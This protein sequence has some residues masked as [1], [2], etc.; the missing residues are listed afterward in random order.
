MKALS[1]KEKIAAKKIQDLTD[2]INYFDNIYYNQDDQKINDFQYDLLRKELDSLEKEYPNLVSKNSPSF[3][4]GSKPTNEFNKIKHKQLMLS[5]NNAYSE[6]EVK[7]FYEDNI[8][9]LKTFEIFA[10]TKVDGLSA[11]LWYERGK[12]IKALTRGDGIYGEDV[13]ENIKYVYGVKKELPKEFPENLEIRGEVFMPKT[14]FND[15]NKERQKKGD[16]K[17]STARNAASGSIRQLDPMITKKRKL[18]FYGYTIISNSNFFGNTISKTR[19][20]LSS[21]NFLLNKPSMLCK[22]IKDLIEF[23]NLVNISRDK[24]EYDIDGIV[25]KVNSYI[26]QEFLGF[27]SRFPRWAL[28]HKFPAE[29]ATTKLLDVKY[30]VGRTGSIT[31]VAILKEVNVGGVK[32][33]RST[34][35]NEEEIYRLKIKIGDTV[36]LE[37]AG[38]VIPKIIKVYKS[39]RNGLEKKIIFPTECPSC[40]NK[41]EKNENEVL[42]RCFNY[43]GCNEQ[44]INRI[45]HFVSRKALNIEGFGEKQVRLFWKHDI[46]KNYYDIFL[47]EEKHNKGQINLLNFEGW[48]EKSISNLFSSIESSSNLSLEKFI[49]ALGI[50]HVGAEIANTLAKNFK[51]IYDLIKVFTIKSDNI[52]EVVNLEGVGSVIINSIYEYFNN[53]SRLE[54]IKKLANKLTIVSKKINHSG[55]FIGQVV[56]LTGTFENYKRKDIENKLIMEGAKVSSVVSKN[57]DLVIVGKEPGSKLD[58]ALKLN[59]TT[60]QLDFIKS[61]MKD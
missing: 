42:S 21:Y 60:K 2:K 32:I 53:S 38:D 7:K 6:K 44:I 26:Q 43:D 34:L 8:K 10:E 3:K 52:N 28:A 29:Q 18:Q 1:K 49:Y 27:T 61:F 33:N 37:R 47:I 51:D 30:Q 39:E 41:L 20:I 57:T 4:V 31:P 36:C 45:I 23:Y 11:S 14:T 40:K 13:T 48:G 24:L 17:F 55:V 58:K 54:I 12:L 5:L 15:L 22:S 56:V 9:K 35:H 25:Y 50:R 16:N 59:I 19:E 46:I